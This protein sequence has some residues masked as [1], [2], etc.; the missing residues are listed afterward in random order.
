MLSDAEWIGKKVNTPLAKALPD[1]MREELKPLCEVIHAD[2]PTCR[3]KVDALAKPYGMKLDV[4]IHPVPVSRTQTHAQMSS[5]SEEDEN[6]TVSP[7]AIFLHALRY[8]AIRQDCA[9]PGCNRTSVDLGRSLLYCSHC[10]RVPYCSLVCQE[11][12]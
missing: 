7:W 12:V 9:A 10:R 8:Q 11:N 5:K 6:D 4:S 1:R 2:F 3:A